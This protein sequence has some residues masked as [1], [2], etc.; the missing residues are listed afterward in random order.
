MCD[1]S[2]NWSIRRL[3][4]RQCLGS[5]SRVP[6]RRALPSMLC[7]GSPWPWASSELCR[8]GWGQVRIQNPS[9]R[10]W[11]AHRREN[12]LCVLAAG[13]L[14]LGTPSV[15]SAHTGYFF[16]GFD[17]SLFSVSLLPAWFH[18]PLL[19]LSVDKSVSS[20]SVSHQHSLCPCSGGVSEKSVWWAHCPHPRCAHA[21]QHP[22]PTD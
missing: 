2:L 3:R 13:P 19:F 10:N 14:H 16:G 7:G 21:P 18:L 11:G 20:W 6:C 15:T 9:T 12:G 17:L 8:S 5:D 4:L 22:Q 1:R